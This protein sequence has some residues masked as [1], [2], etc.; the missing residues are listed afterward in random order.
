[1][2]FDTLVSEKQLT[3]KDRHIN[4]KSYMD[5][6]LKVDKNHVTNTKLNPAA[7]IDR[8]QFDL[9]SGMYILKGRGGGGEFDGYKRVSVAYNIVISIFVCD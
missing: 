4:A 5:I 7:H 8:S 3:R 2:A 6:K 1:M 9:Y